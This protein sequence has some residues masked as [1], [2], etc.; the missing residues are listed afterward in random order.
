MVNLSELAGKGVDVFA[1]QEVTVIDNDRDAPNSV[2]SIAVE[3]GTIPYEV[4]SRLGAGIE[5][6]LMEEKAEYEKL[7]QAVQ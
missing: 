3:L 1:G 2:E 5:R 4:M 6:T 7:T